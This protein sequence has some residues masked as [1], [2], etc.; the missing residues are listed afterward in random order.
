MVLKQVSNFIELKQTYLLETLC[1]HAACTQ[2]EHVGAVLKN[3][4]HLLAV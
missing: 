3:P 2:I 1:L 4:L